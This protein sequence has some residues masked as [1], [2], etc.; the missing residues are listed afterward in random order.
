MLVHEYVRPRPREYD[1]PLV[2]VVIATYNRSEVLRYALRSALDQSYRSLEVIVAG[3]GCTDDSEQVVASF[4]DPRV[5]WIN[6][7][8]NTGNQAG[9]NNAALEIA[10]GE[11]IAYLGHDD[12]WRRDHVALLV[13]AVERG[14]DLAYTVADSIFSQGRAAGRRFTCQPVGEPALPG[15]VMHRRS[16]YEQGVRWPDWR[17]SVDA[18][19]YAFFQ[20]MVA[21]GARIARVPVLTLVKFPASAR[22]NVYRE[23]RSREQERFERRMNRR[24]FV[25]REVA[26][27]IALL[28]LRARTRLPV[29]QAQYTKPGALVAELRRFRGLEGDPLGDGEGARPAG[30]ASAEVE[31]PEPEREHDRGASR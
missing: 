31:S 12:M 26:T 18:P 16:L 30:V 27:G 8:A 23:R 5:R 11:L 6:L 2:T 7:E 29:D 28:P 14:A 1:G 10:N 9:P 4:G 13:A 15:T 24:G 22:R 20:R 3:D 21:A 19:D 25:A 17:E